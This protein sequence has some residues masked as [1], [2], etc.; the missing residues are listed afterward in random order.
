LHFRKFRSFIDADVKQAAG[1][2]AQQEGKAEDTKT[3]CIAEPR[4]TSQ[5]PEDQ[6]CEWA[7]QCGRL[8]G[9]REAQ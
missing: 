9:Y 2:E 6:R 5:R 4:M 3:G 8:L 1:H 7:Q